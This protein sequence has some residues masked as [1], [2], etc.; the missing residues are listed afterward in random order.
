PDQDGTVAPATRQDMPRR[1]RSLKFLVETN[2][3]IKAIATM[4]AE[5]CASPNISSTGPITLP[6]AIT[7]ATKPDR[8]GQGYLRRIPP[9][10]TAEPAQYNHA[11]TSTTVEQAYKHRG[12]HRAKKQLRQWCG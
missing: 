5:V 1:T 2:H 11:D 6:T 7:P 10:E 3:A 4:L 12:V 8:C 9:H